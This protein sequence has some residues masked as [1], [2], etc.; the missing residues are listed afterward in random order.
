MVKE[1]DERGF[2]EGEGLNKEEEEKERR[3][4]H[5]THNG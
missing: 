4:L 1:N 5:H 2:R 3:A